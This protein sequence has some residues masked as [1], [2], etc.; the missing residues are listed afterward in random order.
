MTFSFGVGLVLTALLLL[1]E[2]WLPWKRRPGDLVRYALGSGAILAGLA[3]WLGERGEWLTLAMIAGFY[4]VGGL[5][6]AGAYL[7]DR[8]HNTEQRLRAYERSGE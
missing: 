3:V 4:A 6:T 7:Y 8:Y 5:A 1:V 2:H